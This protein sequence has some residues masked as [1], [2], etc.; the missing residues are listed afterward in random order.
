MSIAVSILGLA[1]VIL[2]HEAGHFF[3]A[4]AVG[5]R[6]RSFN[7]GFG[8]PLVKVRRRGVE[9]AL[10][11]IPF[12]GYVKIPGMHRPAPGDVELHFGRAQRDA[13]QLVGPAERLR[14]ALERDDHEQA[15][16]EL[17]ALEEA[18]AAAGEGKRVEKGVREM[19]DALGADAYWRQAAWR[20]IVTIAAGPAANVALAVVLFWVLFGVAGGK[21]TG[22]VEQVLPG[23]PAAVAGLRPGD[24]IVSINGE[25]LEPGEIV[26]AISGSEGRPLTLVV[27]RDGEPLVLGPVRPVLDHGVYRLGF[28]L[29]AERLGIGESAW[30]A[31]KL[32]GVVTRETVKSLG[33]VVQ[34]EGREQ[35]AS[36]VGIVKESSSAARAG[37]EQYIAIMG[38]ISLS[39]ALLNLLPL[40]PLDGGHI[41]FSLIEGIRGRAVAREVY[42]RVSAVGIALVLLLFFVGL[43]ND[44]GKLGGG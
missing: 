7:L 13:P 5:M 37:W 39:L 34:K 1:M 43:S 18:A 10:R 27:R 22:A 2:V 12:G 14:R 33:R 23:R 41:A 4:L 16:A 11:S 17:A 9:Y 31:L 35:I 21:L 28:R 29:R 38:F 36:P 26:K 8:P 6:P 32:T 24:T 20:R 42:E 44:V 30:R 25:T 40:L 19:R 15:A 3:T